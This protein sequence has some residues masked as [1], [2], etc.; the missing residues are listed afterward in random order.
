M[1]LGLMIGLGIR[2]VLLMLVG[3][4]SK[5]ETPLFTL[6]VGGWHEDFT[7]KVIITL[8]GG[9]FLIYKATKEIHDKLEGPE[10]EA[11]NTKTSFGAVL[12]QISVLNIIFSVDSVVTATG[13]T[14]EIWLMCV[15]MALTVSITLV[16]AYP[17][18]KYVQRHPTLK[19]LGLAFLL[20]IG[21]MLVTE[22]L[23]VEIPHGYVY[24][25]MAFSLGV[26]LLNISLRKGTPVQLHAPQLDDPTDERNGHADS[27]HRAGN[28]PLQ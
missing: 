1:N 12:G 17:I 25:A 6:D 4:L 18:S 19:M 14:T 9:L 27:R 28:D 22:A 3:Y 16:F 10:P 13:M 23:H 11:D 21:V 24:F 26:E 5:L 15:A 8:L 2:V 7:V 20:L